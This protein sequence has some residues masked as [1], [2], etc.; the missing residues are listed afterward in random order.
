MKNSF[1]IFRIIAVLATVCGVLSCRPPQPDEPDDPVDVTEPSLKASFLS[2]DQES[3]DIKL[4]TTG[5]DAVVHFFV[6]SSV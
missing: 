4:E 5:L 1:K 2:S 6:H 3:I